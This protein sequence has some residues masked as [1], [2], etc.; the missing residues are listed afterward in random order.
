MDM[1]SLV[2]CKALTA[3]PFENRE[4]TN[5]ALEKWTT[6]LIENWLFHQA[7]IAVIIGL[8]LANSL[9]PSEASRGQFFVPFVFNIF[10]SSLGNGIKGTHMQICRLL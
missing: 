5:L 7:Q 8:I 4:N 10:I 6:R 2:I 9:Q 3:F 1:F